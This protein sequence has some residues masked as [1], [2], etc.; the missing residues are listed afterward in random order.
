MNFAKSLPSPPRTPP[1]NKPK[2]EDEQ[3]TPLQMGQ[4]EKPEAPGSDKPTTS[5]Y[6]AS[7]RYVPYNIPKFCHFCGYQGY[8]DSCRSIL[9]PS[10]R[11]DIVR[12]KKLC[13]KCLKRHSALCRKITPCAYCG[14]PSHHR[15]LCASATA[16][17][18]RSKKPHH[19]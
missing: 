10:Q 5:G 16:F 17:E 11:A 13:P 4:A 1:T 9:N 14:D 3:A 2:A 6:S 18:Q 8:S 19:C 12:S 7:K 15:A